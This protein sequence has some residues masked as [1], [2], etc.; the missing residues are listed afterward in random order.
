MKKKKQPK[1]FKDF[2]FVTFLESIIVGLYLGVYL[3]LLII[4]PLE[5]IDLSIFLP[6]TIAILGVP[7]FF[8]VNLIRSYKE[9]SKQLKD[10]KIQLG[11]EP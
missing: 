9:F 2:F 7:T 6:I 4:K 11:E 5:I 3:A 8:S 10:I 1:T